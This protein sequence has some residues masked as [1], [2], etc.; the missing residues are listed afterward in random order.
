MTFPP[1]VRTSTAEWP[2]HVNEVSRSI[3]IGLLLPGGVVEQYAR[4][5]GRH[6]SEG[7]TRGVSAEQIANNLALINWTVLAG[8]AVGSFAVVVLARLRT[9]ATRG[10]LFFTALCATVFGLL[11]W[12]SDTSLPVPGASALL[13]SGGSPVVTDP[14]WD[15]PRRV[16]LGALV[17]L[18]AVDGRGDR[19]RRARDLARRRRPRRRVRRAGVRRADLGRRSRWRR[20]ADAPAAGAGASRSAACSRR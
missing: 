20:D 2:S 5:P 12:L 9:E 18:S 17:A 8:L 13:G 16:A 1:G 3:A 7:Y 19:A 6:A 11:A 15:T 4:R 14:A 10:F